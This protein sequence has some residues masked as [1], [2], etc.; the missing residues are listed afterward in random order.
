MNLLSLLPEIPVVPEYNSVVAV[1]P[2]REREGVET[3]DSMKVAK[4]GVADAMVD[5]ATATARAVGA[6]ATAGRAMEAAA[7]SVAPTAALLAGSVAA[8][9]A[10]SVAALLAGPVATLLAS[11]ETVTIQQS[12]QAKEV[13]PT[14]EPLAVCMKIHYLLVRLQD[15]VLYYNNA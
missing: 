11:S 9:L 3:D 8:L 15:I 7:S 12:V 5:C 10:G 6:T 14:L 2:N 4:A 1:T 13:I